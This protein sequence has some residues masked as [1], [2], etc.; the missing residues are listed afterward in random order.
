MYI[1]KNY[2][3]KGIWVLTGAHIIWLTTWSVLVATLYN[4]T[5]Y[6]WLTIPWLPLSVIG[7]SVAFYVGFKNNQAYERLWEARRSGAAL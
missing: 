4:F 1:L 3:L 5:S 6:S 2:S 7:T